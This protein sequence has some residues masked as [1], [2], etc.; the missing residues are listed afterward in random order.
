MLSKSWED[1]RQDKSRRTNLFRDISRIMLSLG[2]IP[3]ARIGSFTLDNTGVLSLT[4]RPLTL[5]L[6]ELENGGIP[7]DIARNDTYTAVE[8]YL[9]DLLAY[10]DSRLRYQPNS[11]NDESD[12]RAQMAVLTGMRAVLP[13]FVSR[14]LRNGPFLFTLTDIHPSN[15]FVDEEWHIK[16]LIDLEWACALPMEMQNPPYWLTN[17]NVDQL[18]DVH[19]DVYNDVREEFMEAFEDEENLQNEGK[20]QL[21]EEDHLL[22]TRTMRTAWE[23]GGYFYFR[24]LEST[25]GLFNLFL[26]HIWPR[27]PTSTAASQSFDEVVSPF[28][29]FGA[30]AFTAEKVKD[31]EEYEARLRALFQAKAPNP[32]A[33]K[34]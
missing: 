10:H 8:P 15:I 19:L 28:W 7:I 21:K 5:R 24:A 23:T 20:L 27:F 6:Q 11:I 29:G 33:S 2:R 16:Y 4:N 30:N 17:R 18:E 3:L 14:D 25:T 32:F 31:R 22:R 9:L 1:K 26:Q 34:D 13:H 12:C